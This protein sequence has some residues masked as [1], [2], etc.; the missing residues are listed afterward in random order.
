VST[1]SSPLSRIRINKILEM[2]TPRSFGSG[3]LLYV[4]T[5]LLYLQVLQLPQLRQAPMNCDELSDLLLNHQENRRI[6]RLRQSCGLFP[7]I[8]LPS[9]AILSNLLEI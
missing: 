9:S 6:H 1:V 8:V 4:A 5:L 7:V 2:L 3:V